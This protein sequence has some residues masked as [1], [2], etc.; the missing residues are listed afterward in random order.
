MEASAECGCRGGG[1]WEGGIQLNLA[2]ESNHVFRFSFRYLL[3]T[4]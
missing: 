2:A 4:R 1:E 3:F